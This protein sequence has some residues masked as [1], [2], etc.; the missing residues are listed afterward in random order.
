M[1][2]AVRKKSE[3]TIELRPHVAIDRTGKEVTFAQDQIFRVSDNTRLGYVGHAPGTAVC[4]IVPV[5]KE[6][7][8]EIKRVVADKFG[9]PPASILTAPVITQRDED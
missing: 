9:T 3:S 2:K 5:D 8:A 4:L 6:T 7:K 1:A